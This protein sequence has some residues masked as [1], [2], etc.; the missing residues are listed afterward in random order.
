MLEIRDVLWWK[1]CHIVALCCELY[2]VYLQNVLEFLEKGI[3]SSKKNWWDFER[4]DIIVK[5]IEVDKLMLYNH[6]IY[7]W[8]YGAVYWLFLLK[9]NSNNFVHHLFI[10]IQLHVIASS[11]FGSLLEYGDV[12]YTVQLLSILLMNPV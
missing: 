2:L 3:H 8:T 6:Q 1:P 10:V 4:Y 9:L 11:T 5:G 7:T 12:R